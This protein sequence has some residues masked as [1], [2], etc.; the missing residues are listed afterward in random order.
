M[1]PIVLYAS[2][3]WGIFACD[4]IEDVHLF[5]LKNFL[6]VSKRTPN[7]LVYGETGRHPLYINATIRCLKYWLRVIGMDES[8]FPQKAYRMLLLDVG[9]GYMNWADRVKDVL[10]RHGFGSVWERQGVHDERTF[11]QHFREVMIRC[12]DQMWESKLSSSDRYI[13]YRSF[14]RIRRLEPYLSCIDKAVFRNALLRFRLGISDL[15][16]HRQ[17]YNPVELPKCCPFCNDVDALDDESHML[18]VCSAFDAI[19]RKY[20]GDV[21]IS[22]SP[23]ETLLTSENEAVLRNLSV[24]LFRAFSMRRNTLPE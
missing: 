11:L 19:R 4:I 1:Q 5:A 22:N 6:S 7:I 8:R 2:E 13:F 15:A 17:R 16:V 23:V 18:H 10:E 14:K 24:F 9:K 21:N 12:Y 20:I 3:V